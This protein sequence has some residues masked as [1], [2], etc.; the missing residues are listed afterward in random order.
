[1][2]ADYRPAY[3]R[4]IATLAVTLEFLDKVVIGL[5]RQ[6]QEWQHHY[7]WERPHTMGGIVDFHGSAIA[8]SPPA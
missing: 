6:L 1:L 8:L 7:S 2:F 4:T 3:H 5:E